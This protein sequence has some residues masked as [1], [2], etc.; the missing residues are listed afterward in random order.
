MRKKP[1]YAAFDLA[2]LGTMRMS[3]E[4]TEIASSLVHRHHIVQ[5]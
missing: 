3:D 1:H 4:A 5:K 2:K